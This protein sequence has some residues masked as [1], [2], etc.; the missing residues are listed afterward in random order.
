[1]WAQILNGTSAQLGDFTMTAAP[2]TYCT[3]ETTVMALLITF[4]ILAQN[5]FF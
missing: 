5:C 4:L 3:R 2:E 1:M